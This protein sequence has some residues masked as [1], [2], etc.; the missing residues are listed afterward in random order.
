M[1]CRAGARSA[2]ELQRIRDPLADAPVS[3]RTRLL[4]VCAFR[5]AF[6]F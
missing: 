6:H 1:R 2:E 3:G 5:R 4:E